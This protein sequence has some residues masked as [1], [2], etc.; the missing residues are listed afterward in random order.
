M[1]I[2]GTLE[3]FNLRELLQMLAFNQKVGTLVLET[4]H[5]TQTVYVNKGLVSF[6]EGDLGA[7]QALLRVIRRRN[8]VPPDRLDRGLKL[9]KAS[10]DYLGKTLIDL[11]A[12]ETPVLNGAIELAMAERFLTLQLTP[13]T[14]FEFADGK[15]LAP[16]GTDAWPD[17][18]ERKPLEPGVVVES[19]LLDLTRK[20]DQWSELNT[21]VPIMTEVYE[22]T[23]LNVD[24]S[25]A[26]EEDE[27][28]IELA[29]PVIA[30]VDGYRTLNEVVR[31]SN[32]DELS[33]VQIVAA[34]VQG[35]AVKPV[36]T[37]DLLIRGTDLLHSGDAL[38]A[39]PLLTRAVERGDAP[40]SARLRVAD[41]LEAC[42]RRGEAAAELDQ[43]ALRASD[44]KPVHVFDALYRAL[45]LREGEL[46]TA[47]RICDFYVKNRPWLQDRQAQA[48]ETLRKLIH[49]AVTARQ[50]QEAARRL[51]EFIQN[52]DAPN[53]DLLVLADLYTSAG[54]R[55]EAA[56][57]L[58]RRAEDLLAGGRDGPARDLL[59]R[60]LQLDPSRSDA[61]G[62]LYLLEGEQR[63]RRQKKRMVVL[64]TGLVIVVVGAA[65]AWWTYNREAG[66]AMRM[67]REQAEQAVASAEATSTDQLRVFVA[68]LTAARE[69]DEPSGEL[70]CASN[71]MLHLV[72][73]A[74]TLA[75]EKVGAFA[76]EIDQ[77]EATDHR[78]ANLG[79]LD[80]L[81]DRL[82]TARKSAESTV[83]TARSE[84]QEAL[85][86]GERAHAAGRFVEARAALR[87][88]RNL[89]FDDE[90]LSSRA[91]MLLGHVD[92]YIEEFVEA[93]ERFLTARGEGDV[94]STYRQGIAILARQLDSDLTRQI[95]LP[96][97]LKSTPPGAQ[98]W[99]DGQDSGLE[100][101]CVLEYSP[102]GDAHLT[103]R[104]P[105]RVPQSFDLPNFTQIVDDPEHYSSLVPAVSAAVPKGPRWT[106]EASEGP[107]SG[108]WSSKDVP[109]LLRSDGRA[110]QPVAPKDGS[111]GAPRSFRRRDRVR[112]G[113]RLSATV[114]WRILG[115]RTLLVRPPDG[116]PWEIQALGRLE[117]APS[118]QSGVVAVVDERGDVHGLDL[119]TGH[120]R[121]RVTLPSPPTQAPVP[122]ALGFLIT[123]IAGTAHAIQAE[124]GEM[125]VLASSADGRLL[126]CPFGK[127]ALLLGGGTAEAR[128][129]TAEQTLERVGTAAPIGVRP[130]ITASGV[131]WVEPGGVKW[132]GV[133]EETPIAV[134]GLGRAIHALAGDGRELYSIDTNGTVRCVH[135][136]EPGQTQ[137]STPLEGKAKHAPV[138]LGDALYIL[139]DGGLYALDR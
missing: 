82:D 102:F 53:E 42:G 85:Q 78:E 67:Q 68:T 114:E 56:T 8:L 134:P 3:T 138:P 92:R 21:I 131:A 105:G 10:G 47:A 123:T 58:F 34:L 48:V 59:R 13:I 88:A 93:R 128:V 15:A 91:N 115:Q 118:M 9:H 5:G 65:A 18:R 60:T 55:S 45:G 133:G 106:I 11:R 70:C 4:D 77:Y 79:V 52:G 124:T 19:L 41:A 81:R 119:Q 126:V 122:S 32:V 132:F 112:S 80:A 66:R 113:G 37:D 139:M 29:D 64:L 83:E 50:P 25:T 23:G 74:L 137:W 33:V 39:L 35:G 30:S 121:W 28:D 2:K 94:R 24:L 130:W 86:S 6:V 26:V 31:T 90:A 104:M 12:V 97:Q 38:R 63:R 136:D 107:F 116:T 51:H 14:R 61:R 100:T 101:P 109:V 95:L 36:S 22:G 117:Q 108:V 72:D 44:E 89:A 46:A 43:Y 57:A 75:E 69:A 96:M 73:Q 49:G 125:R 84:G 54:D 111:L 98:V 27:V 71:E 87:K 76:K 40:L 103:L 129:I 99:V 16:D 1:T 17:G 110:L 62:R 120:Q 135:L 7:T 127:G 20:M